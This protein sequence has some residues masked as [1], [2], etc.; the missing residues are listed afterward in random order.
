MQNRSSRASHNESGIDF[1]FLSAVACME[2]ILQPGHSFWKKVT[3]SE[4]VRRFRG[5]ICGTQ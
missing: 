2:E 5:V 3:T 4:F 1:E